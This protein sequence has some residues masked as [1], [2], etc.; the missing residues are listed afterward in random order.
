M[1]KIF[2]C[3]LGFSLL[4]FLLAVYSHSV[5]FLGYKIDSLWLWPDLSFIFGL[6]LAFF[7]TEF[8]VVEKMIRKII[9]STLIYDIMVAVLVVGY[10]VIDGSGFANDPVYEFAFFIFSLLSAMTVLFLITGLPFAIGE[11][12]FL[13]IRKF[14]CRMGCDK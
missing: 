7:N 2:F 14:R 11:I 13:L 6:L 12:L 10:Y 8:F 5:I 3:N 1:K 4:F 9:F